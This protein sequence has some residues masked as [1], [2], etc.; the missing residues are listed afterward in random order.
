[1]FYL[2]LLARLEPECECVCFPEEMIQPPLPPFVGL[3]VGQHVVA[4]ARHRLQ[5]LLVTLFICCGKKIASLESI[6]LFS[7]RQSN[8][9]DL[10]GLT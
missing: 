3:G 2:S 1:M 5:V 4:E 10:F 9:Y 7:I 8:W 6:S